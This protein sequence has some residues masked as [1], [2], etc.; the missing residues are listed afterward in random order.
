MV[1]RRQPARPVATEGTGAR[2][3]RCLP[4]PTT[5]LPHPWRPDV[6]R[7]VPRLLPRGASVVIPPP[8]QELIDATAQERRDTA[9]AVRELKAVE[10]HSAPIRHIRVADP[11]RDIA[12]PHGFTGRLL[13]VFEDDYE[14]W[15]AARADR[16][17][18]SEI[19][20]ICGWSPFQTRAELL[21]LKRGETERRP[22]SKA[23][24]RG[25]YLEPAVA[26]WFAD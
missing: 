25:H 26:A 5:G 17:G 18:A 7:T 9:R 14:E 22:A 13:G 10:R 19:G 1:G 6:H 8:E 4:R 24:M 23:M 11:W 2:R 15:H 12:V 16:N 21:A 20:V 3:L